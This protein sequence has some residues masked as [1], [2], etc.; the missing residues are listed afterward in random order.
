M[1]YTELAPIAAAL[2][3]PYRG[4][5]ELHFQR[6]GFTITVGLSIDSG[7]VRGIDLVIQRPGWPEIELRRE[8]EGDV[9]AKRSGMNVEVQTGDPAFDGFVY[10][11]SSYGQAVLA[12][13]LASPELRKALGDLVATYGAVSI[14]P[15][16]LTVT[17]HGVGRPLLEPARFMALY[18]LLF[19]AA[20]LFP[21]LPAHAPKMREPGFGLL[22][23]AILGMLAGIASLIA[24]RDYGEPA[25]T[26]LRPLAAFLGVAVVI[27]S[28]PLFKRWM[29]GHSRSATLFYATL[30]LWSIG[31]PLGAM[32]TAVGANAYFDSS[33]PVRRDGKVTA[34][35]SYL[36][37]SEPK[38]DVTVAWNDGVIEALT[39]EDSKP[40]AQI[41]D[42]VESVRRHGLFGVTWLEKAP[43]LV[44]VK[45]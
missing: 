35:K 22:V 1:S 7:T 45:R 43:T 2:G 21:P 10:I 40:K 24:M 3:L 14:T 4:G 32:A 5:A 31:G 9:A 12:P 18:E 37:D 28:A 34:A 26:G 15:D 44:P 30:G 36:D 27:A 13:M 23:L 29:S 25:R 41:G 38:A 16:G 20:R 19:R 6:E 8:T 42:R 39:L 11:E 17:T 33:P